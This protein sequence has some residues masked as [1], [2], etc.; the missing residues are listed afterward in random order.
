MLDVLI[1]KLKRPVD[2]LK[3]SN[4]FDFLLTRYTKQ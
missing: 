3:K 4:G 2:H 1:M